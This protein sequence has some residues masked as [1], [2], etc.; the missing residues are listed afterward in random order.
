MWWD[1]TLQEKRKNHKS[2]C[3]YLHASQ[4]FSEDTLKWWDVSFWAER[5]REAKYAINEEELRPYFA[6]PQVRTT[7]RLLFAEVWYGV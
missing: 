4:G 3:V 6:L 2:I 5:L 1:V 7:C